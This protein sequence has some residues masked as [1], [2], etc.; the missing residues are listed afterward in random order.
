MSSDKEK[1]AI[2][3]TVE[4]LAS[5]TDTKDAQ[6]KW[7]VER[8]AA[9]NRRKLFHEKLMR[10]FPILWRKPEENWYTEPSTPETWFD[11]IYQLSSDI[12][13]V[14][15]QAEEMGLDI[16]DFPHVQQCK[17]KF[18]GLR[19]Y[20]SGGHESVSEAGNK[21][22][23]LLIRNAEYASSSICATCGATEGTQVRTNFPEP[24]TN[25]RWGWILPHCEPCWHE[26]ALKKAQKSGVKEMRKWHYEVMAMRKAEKKNKG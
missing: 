4:Q 9:W 14:F 3:D 17:E 12:E 21:E 15:S 13:K 7:R 22:V 10:D 11:L 26:E 5:E 2:L 24:F 19:F 6:D 1:E 8:E 18:G 20:I 23:A 25:H 16:K